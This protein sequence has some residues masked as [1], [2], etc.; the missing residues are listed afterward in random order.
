MLPLQKKYHQV[1][2]HKIMKDCFLLALLYSIINVSYSQISNE[3]LK[4]WYDRPANKWVEALPVGN[5]RIGAMVFGQVAKEHLQLNEETIWAG[6]PNDANPVEA[7]THLKKIQAL[8][9]QKRFGEAEEWVNRTFFE[10]G[11][12]DGMSYQPAGDLYISFPEHAYPKN[13]YRELDLNT[14]ITT[15]R[16]T[17]N[18]VDYQREVFAAFMGQ[19]IVVRL[20][21]SKKGK[22][23][24]STWLNSPHKAEIKT[25]GKDMLVLHALSGDQEELEGKIRFSIQVKTEVEG[26]RILA[27]RGQLSI[28]N[29]DA[30][31]IYVSMATNY[32][33]YH[34]ISAD[35]DERAS[36]YLNKAIA[37]GYQNLKNE[38]IAFYQNYFNRVKLDLGIS[39]SA[40]KCT[41]VRIKEYA[42]GY[43]PQLVALYFQFGRYLL[44]SCSQPGT[45]PANLQGIWNDQM[46]A[47]WD[48]KYTTNI[49][50]EMNYWPAELTNLSELHQPLFGM[51]Q[52]LTHTGSKTAR[53][54]YGKRGWV[55]HHNTDLWRVS[56][57]IDYA[58]SGMW[59]SGQSWLCQHL[60]EHY[61]YTGDKRFLAD[62]YPAMKGAAQ[63]VLDMLV[64][65]P[66]YHWL[67]LAPSNS[68]ENT[69]T[70]DKWTSNC[71]GVTMDNQLTFDLFTHTVAACKILGIDKAFADTL[72][73]T[74]LRLPPMQIG[75]YSQLQEWMYDWDDST[76]H[77]R[78][79][80]HL[81]GLYPS[82]QITP[83]RTPE[84]FEA[85]RNSLNQRGDV[86]TGW[87]MGWKVCL[88]ARL[89]D[90]NRAGKL[91]RD[92]LHLFN[93]T[94]TDFSG[95]TYPNLFDAHPPFQ[96]DGNFGCTAGIAEMLL[97][98]HNG[99]VHLL[100]AL[101]DSWNKGSVSGLRARGGYTVDIT[102]E[103][104][105]VKEARITASID[106]N[107]RLRV[108]NVLN[109]V[110]K[111]KMKQAKGNNLNV[112][113]P[114]SSI[115]KPI[116][117]PKAHLEISKVSTTFEYDLYMTAGETVVIKGM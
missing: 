114:I 14:A 39:D 9:F 33:N 28:Q 15:T 104:S 71:A 37:K 30:I 21:A 75:Q 12:N 31:T 8:I 99:A 101:P 64:E 67:V 85:A 56:R 87:S 98:S 24:C 44:I 106:G 32:N 19:I 117:S 96:I 94:R 73:Q 42:Q 79:V 66:E 13:Y 84:L 110:G 20:T 52:D 18:D 23:N 2:Q 1:M 27:E 48:S 112:F 62:Y 111:G 77:H 103:N 92:Q 45:Q 25:E 53:E 95:G 63:F 26:G 41:D 88:W 74:L 83:D 93:D 89:C 80:S 6:E 109:L 58:A 5:G 17:V 105:K 69:F 40:K 60:W 10:E 43:D 55:L 49:N 108:A 68:P 116:V 22:L 4:L 70:K 57:P 113:Y 91:I 34:D 3:Y 54:M 100:P 65:E 11:I 59:L 86:A 107:L 72:Q 78:H 36:N 61:L 97:Q 35:D 115:P 50:T 81:Y 16:Y 47:P 102:W 51:I 82:N 76:D 29:A 46:E 7:R 90:G 38:H